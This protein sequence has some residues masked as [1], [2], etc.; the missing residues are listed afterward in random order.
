MTSA[1]SY[2]IGNK[3]NSGPMGMKEFTSNEVQ[4]PEEMPKSENLEI[5]LV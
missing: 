5:F 2:F 4:Q 1:Y 3:H